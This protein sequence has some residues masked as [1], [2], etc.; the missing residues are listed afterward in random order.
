VATST[1]LKPEQPGKIRAENGP[2]GYKLVPVD[3][4][5]TKLIWIINSDLKGWLPQ[6][7]IDQSLSGVLPSSIQRLQEYVAQQRLEGTRQ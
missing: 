4:N 5:R 7:V 6:G 3:A 1:S 2:C